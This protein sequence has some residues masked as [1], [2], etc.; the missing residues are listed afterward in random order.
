VTRIIEVPAHF[1][2]RSFDQFAGD[3][4]TWPPEEKLL[5]DAR[6]AQ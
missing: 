1:D 5:L 6:G 3:F 4:G 2:D